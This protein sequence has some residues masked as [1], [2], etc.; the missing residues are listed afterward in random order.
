MLWFGE[1]CRGRLYMKQRFLFAAE[2]LTEQRQ[3]AFFSP[4]FVCLHKWGRVGE[5]TN[6]SF[7]ES[8]CAVLSFFP[9]TEVWRGLIFLAAV[10]PGWEAET[11]RASC[12]LWGSLAP[13]NMVFDPLWFLWSANLPSPHPAY[14]C[15]YVCMYAC[16]YMLGQVYQTKVELYCN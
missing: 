14:V 5:S 8:M 16:M 15:V 3:T 10:R 4:F 9:R 6:K 1:H 2:W 12:F 7:S 11:A 13:S